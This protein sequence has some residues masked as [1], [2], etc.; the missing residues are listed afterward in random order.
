MAN[1]S[2][3]NIQVDNKSPFI[4]RLAKIV[5]SETRYYFMAVPLFQTNHERLR[6]FRKPISKILI[7]K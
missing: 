6:V 5:S 2:L 3:K 4:L 1:S 7:N